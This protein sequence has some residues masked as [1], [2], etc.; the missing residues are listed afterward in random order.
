MSPIITS[1]PTV[2][3]RKKACAEAE[4]RLANQSDNNSAA[5]AVR[6][7]GCAFFMAEGGVEGK[8]KNEAE[9]VAESAGGQRVIGICKQNRYGRCLWA[10]GGWANGFDTYGTQTKDSPTMSFN[11]GQSIE[12]TVLSMAIHQR[13]REP[14]DVELARLKL[15]GRL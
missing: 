13:F 15:P 12:V 5:S 9:N 2:R 3:H 4:W 6:Q 14:V 1:H 11:Y 7:F 8:P 10:H